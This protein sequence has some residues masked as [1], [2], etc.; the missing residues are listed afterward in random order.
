MNKIE[1][2]QKAGRQ[3]MKIDKRYTK[4]I[5]EKVARLADFPQ[6]A[7]DIKKMHGSENQYRLRVGDYRVLFE[8]LDGV[9]K[10]INIQQ[11][12]RRTTQTYKN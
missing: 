7:L 4:A 9:P 10:I 5:I 1:W 12:S 2:S 6:V 3:L 11:I 8:V